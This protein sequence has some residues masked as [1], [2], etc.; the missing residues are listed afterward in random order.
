MERPGGRR[1]PCVGAIVLDDRGRLLLVRRGREP[2]RG[3]WSVPGGKVEPGEAAGDALVREVLEETAL[4][5]V[6]DVFVGTVEKPAPG[7]DVF[8][9]ED[10]VARLAP[11]T[12]PEDARAGDDAA[13]VGW[14]TRSQLDS[15][16]V[17]D[18]LLE[19]LTTW[20]VLD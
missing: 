9:I 17:V 5:V 13:D 14:F 11:G 15:L 10:F 12:L 3:L 6:P 16:P 2:A 8:V 18:G 7:G 19:A 20:G 1:I 4:S